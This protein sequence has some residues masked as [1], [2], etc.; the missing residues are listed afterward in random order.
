M[1]GKEIKEI[2]LKLMLTTREFAEKLGV[3]QST[4]SSWELGKHKISLRNM[5][6]IKE[7]ERGAE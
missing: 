6:K 4:V 3:T 1:L 5:R 7:L 2:R